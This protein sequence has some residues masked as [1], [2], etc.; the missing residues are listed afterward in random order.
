[1]RCIETPVFSVRRATN[2]KTTFEIGEKGFNFNNKKLAKTKMERL[3]DIFSRSDEPN[4]TGIKLVIA[5]T[6]TKTKLII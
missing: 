2:Q 1:M 4:L 3:D 5:S 6:Q